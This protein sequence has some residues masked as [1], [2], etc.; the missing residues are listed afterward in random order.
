[1]VCVTTNLPRQDYKFI[2]FNKF[3]EFL[4]NCEGV[5]LFDQFQGSKENFL[6]VYQISPPGITLVYNR[7]TAGINILLIGDSDKV[8]GIDEKIQEIL[9]IK[10]E[11]PVDN[12]D[13][14]FMNI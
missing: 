7:S 9:I 10:S 13:S 8:Q 5:T 14:N 6:R 1:M 12:T 3:E 11:H 4:N 2:N